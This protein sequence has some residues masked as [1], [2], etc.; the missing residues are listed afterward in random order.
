[1]TPRTFLVSTSV[2]AL[3]FAASARADDVPPPAPPVVA[4]AVGVAFEPGTPAFADVLK[5]AKETGKPVFID[6]MTET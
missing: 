1:M 2:L 3:A 5:K 6:F 4:P